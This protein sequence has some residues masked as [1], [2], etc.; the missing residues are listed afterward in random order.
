MCVLQSVSRWKGWGRGTMLPATWTLLVINDQERWKQHIHSL[1][2]NILPHT[3]I[4]LS[5]FL[6]NINNIYVLHITFYLSSQTQTHMPFVVAFAC[7]FPHD[8][9]WILFLSRE[10]ERVFL[11]LLH[12]IGLSTSPSSFPHLILCPHAFLLCLPFT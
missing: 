12:R 3:R 7:L 11:S 9:R 2:Y 10:R 6:Y 8:P 1:T 4:A 5:F